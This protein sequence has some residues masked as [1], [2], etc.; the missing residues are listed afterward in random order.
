MTFAEVS[1]N[2]LRA[3]EGAKRKAMSLLALKS[4]TWRSAELTLAVLSQQLQNWQCFYSERQNY[5]QQTINLAVS[6]CPCFASTSKVRMG[7]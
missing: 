3:S 5:L 7:W 6:M 1:L 4:T 2:I